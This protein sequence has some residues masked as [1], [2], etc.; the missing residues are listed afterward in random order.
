MSS[1][2][3][4]ALVAGGADYVQEA[5]PPYEEGAVWAELVDGSVAELR[6]GFDNKWLPMEEQ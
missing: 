2:Q 6:I 3:F 5:E 4:S 1:Q